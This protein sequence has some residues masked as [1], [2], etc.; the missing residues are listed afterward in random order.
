V[1]A[2]AELPET[3]SPDVH[4]MQLCRIAFE[5]HPSAA[6]IYVAGLLGDLAAARVE[7]LVRALTP[8]IRALRVDLRAVDMI[9]PASFVRIARVLGRWR[10]THQPGRVAFEFPARSQTRRR[11]L[12][13]VDQ[14]NRIGKPVSTA[15]SWPMSTSPG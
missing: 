7:E 12:R 1:T 15:M 5:S 2:A 6:T 4:H 11:H 3:T 9:E 13:L 10:E 14:P 8:D